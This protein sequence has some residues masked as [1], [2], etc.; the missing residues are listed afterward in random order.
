MEVARLYEYMSRVYFYSNETLPI[1][2]IVLRFLNEAEKAGTSPELATA[3]ASL[4]VL[5]GFAQLYNLANSYVVWGLSAA[6]KVN[7]PSNRITV[8]VVTGVYKFMLGK[9]DEVRAHALEAKVLCEQ[10]GDA[11]PRRVLVVP[12]PDRGHRRLEHLV[13][14]V[15][16]GEALPE[17]DRV[18]GER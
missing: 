12:R 8:N 9:W 17:V 2:Y 13:G 14:P 10:L 11:P 4:A 15:G 3:Y 7:Q 1:M 5:A 6:E 18:V 16:V